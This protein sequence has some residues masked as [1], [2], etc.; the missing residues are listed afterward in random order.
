M[1]VCHEKKMFT[2]VTLPKQEDM[3]TAHNYLSRPV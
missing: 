1:V 3:Y 2:V